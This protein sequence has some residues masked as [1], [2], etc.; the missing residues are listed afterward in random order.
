MKPQTNKAF[1]IDDISAKFLKMAAPICYPLS[2]LLNISIQSGEYPKMLKK[3]KVTPIFKKGNTSDPNNYR[4]I[5]IIPVISS[6]FEMHISNFVT[7]FI[8]M[9]SLIYHNQSGFRKNH[10]C[11]TALTKL[12]AQM[13]ESN[14]VGVVLAFD[15]VSH[16]IILKKLRSYKFDNHSL[17][18]FN[19][20]LSDRTQLVH[21]SV[22]LSTERDIKAGVAQGSVFII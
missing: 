2:H 18:W 17:A 15:E 4:P 9:H 22:K 5:S 14:T 7:K 13:N 20:Y 21:I 1:G 11:Q 10:S 19:S 6:I 8:D 16:K 3:A 12:L